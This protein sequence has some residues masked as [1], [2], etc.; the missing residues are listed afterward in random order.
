MNKPTTITLIVALAAMTTGVLMEIT[1][2]TPEIIEAAAKPIDFSFPD[3]SDRMQ[4]VN[5][6]R[7][8]VLVINFWATWCAPCLQEIPEFIKLQSKFAQRGL[9]FI[10]VA[11]DDKDPVTAYLKNIEINYPILI[12]G[13]AGIGLSQQFGNIINAV[14]FT[15]I[16]NQAGE[17]VHRQPGEI[18]TDQLLEILTPLFSET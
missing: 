9:Q 11:I 15:V 10:G 14:P 2:Q 13:D 3:A 16:V 18:S 6:W 4:S 17:I 12:A 8:K 5:Q 7:G 1:R